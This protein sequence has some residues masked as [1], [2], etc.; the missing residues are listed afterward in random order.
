MSPFVLYHRGEQDSAQA[1]K[2]A[3]TLP[4]RSLRL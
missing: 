2:F 4:V 1:N 3:W